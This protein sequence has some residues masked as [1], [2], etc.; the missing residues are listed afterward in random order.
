MYDLT[1]PASVGILYIDQTAVFV[2]APDEVALDDAL[3]EAVRSLCAEATSL[4]TAWNEVIDLRVEIG[5]TTPCPGATHLACAKS[6]CPGRDSLFALG[7][8]PQDAAQNLYALLEG[9][10]ARLFPHDQRFLDRV[11]TAQTL[12]ARAELL[13]VRVLCAGLPQTHPQPALAM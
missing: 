7:A 13:G 10:A 3:D 5:E 11:R 2:T 8:D 12:P 1:T 9:E 6:L 4:E